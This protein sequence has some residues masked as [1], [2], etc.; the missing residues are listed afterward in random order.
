MKL[1]YIGPFPAWKQIIEDKLATHH[2]YGMYE[3]INS[4]DNNGKSIVG[5]LKNEV[6]GG[7][8]YFY[9]AHEKYFSL[10]KKTLLVIQRMLHMVR[11]LFII[12]K[13]DIVYDYSFQITMFYGFLKKMGLYK[14][15]KFIT[16]LH[17]PG[18]FKLALTLAGGSDA[19]IFFTSLHY[20][21]A[22]QINPKI[23]NRCFLNEWYPDVERYENYRNQMDVVSSEYFFIDN[24]ITERDHSLLLDVCARNKIPTVISERAVKN[25]E[26]T[27][28][29]SVALYN[30]YGDNDNNIMELLISSKAIVIPLKQQRGMLAP[31]G[32][33]SFLDAIA[34]RIPVI[35]SDNACFA[36][37]IADNKI[38][39]V[40]KTSSADDLFD[41]MK[42][43]YD[44][45]T[46]YD[47]LKE[48]MIEFSKN[49]TIKQTSKKL[50]DII[51]DTMKK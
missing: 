32:I 23:R 16:W 28:P 43:L 10:F 45:K 9:C 31:Y 50:Q 21:Y 8:I 3:L 35:C 17:N 38:G 37:Q 13:Y 25:R 51:I 42:M 33:T 6:G 11:L 26:I 14:K 20:D 19:Y 2:L 29:D 12:A 15:T 39:L 1:L 5:N 49:R 34:L 44:D 47:E 7:E 24:G 41:K 4:F 22:M 30:Y 18:Y 36:P 27:I 46:L 48:N 40:Y